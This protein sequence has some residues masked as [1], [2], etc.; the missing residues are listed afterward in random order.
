VVKEGEIRFPELPE[1]RSASSPD[2]ALLQPALRSVQY[3]LPPPPPNQPRRYTTVRS[4]GKIRPRLGRTEYRNVRTATLDVSE[5]DEG[6]GLA[7]A[8]S[9]RWAREEARMTAP[10]LDVFGKRIE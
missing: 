2:R 10:P 3:N 4:L 5:E 6:F 1:P 8:D 7:S 9:G